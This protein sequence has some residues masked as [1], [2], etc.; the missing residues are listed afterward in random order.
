M[1]L[2][3]AAACM[4]K[5]SPHSTHQTHFHYPIDSIHSEFGGMV[6]QPSIHMSSIFSCVTFSQLTI[7]NFYFYW[8]FFL[9][10]IHIVVSS[11]LRSHPYEALSLIWEHDV[12]QGCLSVFR[13]TGALWAPRRNGQ[14]WLWLSSGSQD[15]P[16]E[17]NGTM[18]IWEAISMDWHRFCFPF[19]TIYQWRLWGR[20]HSESSA[21][22][23]ASNEELLPHTLMCDFKFKTISGDFTKAH[24]FLEGLNPRKSDNRQHFLSCYL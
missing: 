17:L 6:I 1:T 8:L 13:D 3:A 14:E 19:R 21:F 9:K 23:H 11:W 4:P 15:C 7:H 10:K 20:M 2:D 18:A 16:A 24:K 5:T 12:S 22:N